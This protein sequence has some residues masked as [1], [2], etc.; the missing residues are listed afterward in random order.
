MKTRCLALFL[1]ALGTGAPIALVQ[2]APA[3]PPL[4]LPAGLRVRVWTY[5]LAGQ[6][7]EGTLRS[8]DSSAVKLS[9]RSEQPPFAEEM[10]L[11]GPTSPA[12]TWRW[13]RRTTGGK[14]R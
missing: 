12:W 5:S 4:K 13:A 1:A 14:A 7:I 2:T 11:P 6:R 8:A 9:P 3:P 10:T